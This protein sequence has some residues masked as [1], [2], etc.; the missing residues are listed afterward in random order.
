MFSCGADLV[1]PVR[2]AKAVLFCLSEFD[3]PAAY[4]FRYMAKFV[5]IYGELILKFTRLLD[6]TVVRPL[7]RW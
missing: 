1:E 6:C 3:V 4:G 5:Y 2:I 7:R